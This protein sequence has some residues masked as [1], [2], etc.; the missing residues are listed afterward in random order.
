MC[1]EGQLGGVEDS[2]ERIESTTAG[3]SS[4]AD[5]GLARLPERDALELRVHHDVPL[6]VRELDPALRREQL[7]HVGEVSAV[8]IR[9]LGVG[10]NGARIGP[11][12]LPGHRPRKG[13]SSPAG[14]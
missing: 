9:G 1:F 12:P 4:S 7:R 5:A 13:Q 3:G 11:V 10:D 8:G 2:T 6:L 14:A